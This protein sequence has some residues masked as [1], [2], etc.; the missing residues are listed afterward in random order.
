MWKFVLAG[1]LCV[2]GAVGASAEPKQSAQ[3]SPQ[4]TGDYLAQGY[5]IK[6]VVNNTF[7]L[8][9]K[10][11]RAFLCGAS[12]PNLTWANWAEMTRNATCTSLSNTPMKSA[13]L[14]QG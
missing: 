1:L 3:A 8:L 9:Q 4:T 12:T 13:S 14:A 11:D 7:L 10:G 2:F 6:G 5:E